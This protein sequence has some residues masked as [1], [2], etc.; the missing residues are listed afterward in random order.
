MLPSCKKNFQQKNHQE[1]LALISKKK[2]IAATVRH[3]HCR[4][5]D[6]ICCRGGPLPCYPCSRGLAATIVD[7]LSRRPIS[8]TST[9]THPLCHCCSPTLSLAA[10]ARSRSPEQN[11]ARSNASTIVAHPLYFC[12]HSFAPLRC[13]RQIRRSQPTSRGS[14]AST[15]PFLPN[16]A[17]VGLVP[18]PP[19]Q[20]LILCC[21]CRGPFSPLKLHPRIRRLHH[22]P[23]PLPP[24]QFDLLLPL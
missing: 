15:V 11:L 3:H 17:P 22:C 10:A 20:P 21:C 9:A 8:D 7:A 12:C 2:S 19:P 14:S 13:C 5:R 1:T 18:S 4:S 24:F 6:P 16:P 23:F